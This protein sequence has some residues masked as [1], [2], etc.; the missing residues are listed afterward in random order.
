MARI[1]KSEKGVKMSSPLLDIIQHTD[2]LPNAMRAAIDQGLIA[3]DEMNATDRAIAQGGRPQILFHEGFT[4]RGRGVYVG[5][6]VKV[7]K[8]IPLRPKRSK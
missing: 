8:V 1:L 4:A 2:L 5:R 6:V 7:G 3:E